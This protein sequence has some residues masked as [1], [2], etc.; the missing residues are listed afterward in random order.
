[1]DVPLVVDLDGTL[2]PV[3]TLVESLIK[4]VKHHPATLLKLPVWLVKGRAEFKRLIASH[5]GPHFTAADLPYNEALLEYLRNEKVKGRSIILAT[6]A[7]RSI[8]DSVA[9]HLG[10]FDAVL[11]SDGIRNLK[12]ATK[13]TVIED[14]VGYR[15]AYIGDHVADLP[16]WRA[17]DA[18][19]LVGVS[20]KVRRTVC[21]S[22]S[23]ER[24]FSKP[25]AG[26]KTWVRALRMHQWIKNLLLFV[27]LITAFS[28]FDTGKLATMTLAFLAFSLLASATYIINDLLD[29]DNDRAHPRKRLRPFA[30]A[31]IS[32]L[33]GATV[34]MVLLFTGLLIAAF[35]S[36]PFFVTLV[37]YLALTSAYTL[38]LKRCV[39]IDVLTLSML[40]TIRIL[41]GSVA[42]GIV[43][44]YWLAAFSVFIFLSLA[45]VKRCSELVLLNQVDKDIANGRDYHVSDLRVLWPLGIAAALCSI[46]VFGLFINAPETQ[47]RYRSPEL[48]WLSAFIMIYWISRIWI[49]T[50]RGEMH[51]DPVVY[52]I[53]NPNSLT[54]VCTMIGIAL[55]AY[56][57]PIRF[58]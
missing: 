46:V 40:Y 15:F 7:D 25:K 49:M 26:V 16:I 19:L 48:L 3:D 43:V 47:A 39:L 6:A 35:I 51:D 41:A 52:A 1:M 11:A 38:L 31:Q 5:A 33:T 32:P 22:C 20:S 10:L 45:L 24:E 28:L 37:C 54:C 36:Q 42:V 23:V 57:I 4:T 13:L 58:P 12:G 34:S 56:F 55:V 44:S 18:A 27:P 8:A 2:T 17:A 50:G 9:A 53:K 14:T 30:C 29:L 21:E